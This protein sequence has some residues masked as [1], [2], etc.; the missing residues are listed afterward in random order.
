MSNN[1]NLDSVAGSNN[2]DLTL[3][4][5]DLDVA[6]GVAEFGASIPTVS[7]TPLLGYIETSL[8][9]S[10]AVGTIPTIAYTALP[11]YIETSLGLTEVDAKVPA[12]AYSA[13]LGRID[14]RLGVA[15]YIGWPITPTDSSRHLAPGLV[16][17]IEYSSDGT[18]ITF[19]IA[20]LIG[21]T[22]A[23]ADS[24]TGDLR[25]ILQAIFLKST[26]YYISDTW[27]VR[28]RTVDFFGMNLLNS[29]TFDR[30]FAITFYVDMGDP[31]V[32]PEP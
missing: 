3:T 19:P 23:E 31:N 9:L 8:G 1:L 32:A 29:R 12:F 24:V 20:N 18:N 17:G 6:L 15:E 27:S 5:F 16:F 22:A 14:T 28:L 13:L 4:L 26:E 7:S 21:L 30:H 25:E 10:E 2:L 11:G